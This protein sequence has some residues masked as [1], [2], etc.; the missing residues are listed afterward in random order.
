VT[1]GSVKIPPR[2]NAVGFSCGREH[3]RQLGRI[4]VA[5]QHG[6]QELANS[7]AKANLTRSMFAPRSLGNI[8]A[9]QATAVRRSQ[10]SPTAAGLVVTI[11]GAPFPHLLC[12]FWLAF[13]GWQYVKAICR[14]ER[15]SPLWLSA[16]YRFAEARLEMPRRG[17][18]RA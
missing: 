6:S 1:L 10:I 9:A 13:S 3:D 11:A 8:D 2:L 16:A 5:F 12:H 15:A 7:I 14:R 18:S 4:E 17:L